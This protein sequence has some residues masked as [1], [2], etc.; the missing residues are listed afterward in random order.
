MSQA[1]AQAQH[2]N[3][4]GFSVM[5]KKKGPNHCDSAPF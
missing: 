3:T 2:K 4:F 5:S 1:Q